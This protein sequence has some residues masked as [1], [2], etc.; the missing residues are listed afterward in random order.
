[1]HVGMAGPEQ[2][3]MLAFSLGIQNGLGLKIPWF[4]NTIYS[5]IINPYYGLEPGLVFVLSIMI[6]QIFHA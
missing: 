1:M 2:D 3:C 4:G 5:L 6:G